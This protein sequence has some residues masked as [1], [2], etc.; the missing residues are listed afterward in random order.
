MEATLKGT[1]TS[2][3]E[4]SI[5]IDD[6]E[7]DDMVRVTINGDRDHDVLVDRTDL[8]RIIQAFEPCIT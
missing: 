4:G 2:G 7:R 1:Q 8:I 5:T 6:D 3:G